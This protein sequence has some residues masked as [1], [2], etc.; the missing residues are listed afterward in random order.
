MLWPFLCYH[1]IGFENKERKGKVDEQK[2]I[3][4]WGPER[5]VTEF[6]D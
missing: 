3:R 5:K 2:E 4:E 6:I 1:N